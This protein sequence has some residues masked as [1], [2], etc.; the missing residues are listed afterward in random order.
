MRNRPNNKGVSAMLTVA[1]FLGRRVYTTILVLLGDYRDRVSP[2]MQ[3]F[4]ISGPR[5]EYGTLHKGH[6]QKTSDFKKEMINT[7]DTIAASGMKTG[8]VPAL[9]KRWEAYKIDC[10]LYA[11]DEQY[12]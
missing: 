10:F 5:A 1:S 11:Q 3:H 2:A 7:I 12:K 8:K 4:P 6:K 9:Q